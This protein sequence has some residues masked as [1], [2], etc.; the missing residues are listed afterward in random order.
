MNR[1][2]RLATVS[3][4]LA[5][6][7]LSTRAAEPAGYVDLGS[8]APT[9]GCDFVE[10]NINPSM[11]KIAALFADHDN[12]DAAELLRG[13]KRVRVNVVGYNDQTKAD[14]TKRVKGIREGLEA[15][16][17]NQAVTV[18]Q[19]RDDQD[20]AVYVKSRDEEIVEGLLVTVVDPTE[21]KVVLV[22]VVGDIK[23]EQLAALGRDLH[24][25]PIA[26][27]KALTPKDS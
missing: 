3:S 1:L 23:P 18:R 11:L 20:V 10:V 6:A 15:R 2:L 12:H 16:G 24:I 26:D 25:E 22:N 7:A 27:L 17:W 4:A 21:H 9:D 8:F 14:L 5:L 19:T 13:L